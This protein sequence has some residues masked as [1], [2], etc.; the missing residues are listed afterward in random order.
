V[1]DVVARL[2]AALQPDDSVIGGGN[3]KKLKA[4]PP[5]SRRGENANAVRGGF[6]LWA[7]GNV[8]PPDLPPLR[9]RSVR[10]IFRSI[11]IEQHF[12]ANETTDAAGRY[13]GNRTHIA[14]PTEDKDIGEAVAFTAVFVAWCIEQA[15]GSPVVLGLSEEE[16]P[17]LCDCAATMIVKYLPQND[18]MRWK[19]DSA[20]AGRVME[21]MIC[22]AMRTA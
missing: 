17:L 6:R 16:L 1:A 15:R 3:V 11:G 5:G 2:I 10:Q 18:W 4:P 14:I 22:A 21:F 19:T 9:T 13:R 20:I 12:A 7:K 8:V